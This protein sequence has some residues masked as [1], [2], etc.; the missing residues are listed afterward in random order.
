MIILL[1]LLLT[2]CSLFNFETGETTRYAT[3][4][5]IENYA[6]VSGLNYCVEDAQSLS[7]FLNNNNFSVKMKTNNLATKLNI[8]NDIV[9]TV[10]KLK[11]ED[12]YVFYFSGHGLR[13]NDISYIVPYDATL[14]DMNSF[15]SEK[16][17]YNWL[18]NSKSEKVLLIFDKC[19]SGAY[20][21]YRRFFVMTASMEG[22]E[23]IEIPDLKHGLFTYYL[24]K[25]LENK[26]AD[27]NLDGNVTFSELYYFTRS[28]VTNYFFINSNGIHTNQNPL[29]LGMTNV[30]MIFY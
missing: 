15:I 11:P 9:S 25:G 20:V 17:L 27:I 26:K 3:I 8:S 19:F 4:Y 1:F 29:F 22:E 16:E 5:G 6:Y 13:T 12:I 21:A 10:E 7:S 23:S 24:L 14:S 28:Y 18:K 30:E 2:S